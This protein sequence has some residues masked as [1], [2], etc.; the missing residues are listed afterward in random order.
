[1]LL[2]STLFLLHRQTHKD[3]HHIQGNLDIDD[4]ERT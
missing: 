2:I 4:R 1:M 3:I